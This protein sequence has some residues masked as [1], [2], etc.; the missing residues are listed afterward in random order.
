LA[1]ASLSEESHGVVVELV[2]EADRAAVGSENETMKKLETRVQEIICDV[3]LETKLKHWGVWHKPSKISRK[4]ILTYAKESLNDIFGVILLLFIAVTLIRFVPL[5]VSIYD[6][7]GQ[8]RSKYMIGFELKKHVRGVG[9]DIVAVSKFLF[10]TICIC[11]L[12]VGVPVFLQELPFRSRNLREATDCAKK[13]LNR[14]CKYICEFFALIFAWRTIELTFTSCLY[15]VL[16]P[17]ICLTEALPRENENERPKGLVCSFYICALFWFGLL[18]SAITL[19]VQTGSLSEH[20]R[21]GC[22]F[23]SCCK[24]FFL[25]TEAKN[26]SRR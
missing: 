9:E 16:V 10:Y 19:S 25:Q 2:A 17:A 20:G 22:D 6:L 26:P 24:R 14:T 12:V 8:K 5:L 1:K 23:T 3:K 7:E 18:A 11:V 4:I 15:C 13:N 21:C